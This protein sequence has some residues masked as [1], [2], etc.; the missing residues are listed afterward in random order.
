MSLKHRYQNLGNDFI[1]LWADRL[2]ERQD[3]LPTNLINAQINIFLLVLISYLYI[4]SSGFQ[5]PYV[6]LSTDFPVDHKIIYK[7]I[8]I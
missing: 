8:F 4:T 6:H 3:L 5:L 7:L 2:K 1:D